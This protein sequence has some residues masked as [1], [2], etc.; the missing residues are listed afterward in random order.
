MEANPSGMGEIRDRGPT[1]SNTV[2]LLR[3]TRPGG[4]PAGPSDSSPSF[5]MT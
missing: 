4:V 2:Q 3:L 5:P 1:W